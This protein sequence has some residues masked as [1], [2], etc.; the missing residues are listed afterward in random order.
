MFDF[1]VADDVQIAVQAL[2][3]TR[4]RDRPWMG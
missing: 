1:Q 4:M 2:E 3:K